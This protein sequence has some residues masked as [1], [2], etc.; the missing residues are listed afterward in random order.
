MAGRSSRGH[1]K[2]GTP[3]TV[4][5]QCCRHR[6]SMKCARSNACRYKSILQACTGG[7][8]LIDCCNKV[9]LLTPTHRGRPLAPTSSRLLTNM[10]KT[11]AEATK[12]APILCH[13]ALR[14]VFYPYDP[15]FSPPVPTSGAMLASLPSGS[16]AALAVHALTETAAADTATPAAFGSYKNSSNRAQ[17][18][19]SPGA[20]SRQTSNPD[21]DVTLAA[22]YGE[23]DGDSDY[24]KLRKNLP[25]SS[26]RTPE[27][28][29]QIQ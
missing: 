5:H 9:P 1:P 26:A 29:I 2:T 22:S 7:C 6:P 24:V 4:F 13:V 28:K 19:E 11:I 18:M 16:G 3:G 25:T 15:V 14:V 21:S 17:S 20:T 12:D 8:L 10:S 27:L 23:I